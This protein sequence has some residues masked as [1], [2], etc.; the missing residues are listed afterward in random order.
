MNPTA[1]TAVGLGV[2]LI[3]AVFIGGGYLFSGALIVAAGSAMDALDGPLARASGRS[4]DRG[5]V[6]DSLFD[7]LGETFM[8]AG[9]AAYV[10]GQGVLVVLSLLSLGFSFAISYLRSKAESLVIEGT[11]G[12]MARPARIVLYA[13]GVGLGWIEPMLWLMVSLNAFTIFQR[14]SQIWS[15]LS[16]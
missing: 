14:L 3:G 10:S 7:R 4:S 11:A 8:W 12:W 6:L 1:V 5:A 2:T 9:L 13:L 15:R 16:N